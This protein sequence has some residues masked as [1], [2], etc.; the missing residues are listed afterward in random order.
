VLPTKHVGLAL[1]AVAGCYAPILPA[2]APCASPESSQRCPTGLVCITSGSIEVCEPP[3]TVEIDASVDA[4]DAAPP[5]DSDGD[6]VLDVDDNCPFVANADQADED[7]DHVGDA[8][9]PCPPFADATDSDQDGVPDA[10]DP[11]PM[12]AG[13]TIVAFAG[14]RAAPEGWTRTG[15]VSFTGGN[16]VMVGTETTAATLVIASSVP[17][18]STILA[19]VKLTAITSTGLNLGSVSV[20]DQQQPNTDKSVACQLSALTGGVDASLRIFD[21]ATSTAVDAAPH[22]FASGGTFVLELQRDGTD[23]TC[24]ASNPQLQIT[25]ADQLSTA[26]HDLGLRV[27]G[28]SARFEWVMVLTR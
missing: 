15:D 14:F 20:I 1:A 25:G 6:G 8:C 2:G 11:N 3:G 28:A 4:P 26:N 10:C 27:K 23:Y 12:V 24:S 16:A 5:L 7:G 21:T 18:H 19:S 22:A 17:L 9:D 13:D